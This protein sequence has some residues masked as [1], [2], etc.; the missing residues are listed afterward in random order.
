MGSGALGRHAQTSKELQTALQDDLK[1]QA[2]AEQRTV[3]FCCWFSSYNASACTQ[4]VDQA[5]KRAV[6]Q[7]VDYDTFKNMVT[8][9]ILPQGLIIITSLPNSA[10]RWPWLT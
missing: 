1:R 8:L 3:Q 10:F 9:C 4:A 2:S 7:H 5:K 6:G